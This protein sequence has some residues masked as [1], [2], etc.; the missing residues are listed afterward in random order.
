[1][2]TASKNILFMFTLITLMAQGA[3]ALS[4][5]ITQFKKV[6]ENNLNAG[7]PGLSCSSDSGATFNI[8]L[9]SAAPLML[10]ELQEDGNVQPLALCADAY[11]KVFCEWGF[12]NEKW[13]SVD[14]RDIS[15]RDGSYLLK[16]KVKP[17]VTSSTVEKLQCAILVE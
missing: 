8:Y 2:K 5:D 4:L 10:S 6:V 14:L 9:G 3:S 11:S 16:G 1:M 17:R 15:F 7:G 12:M 13:I